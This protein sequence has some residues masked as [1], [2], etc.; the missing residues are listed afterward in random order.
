MQTSPEQRAASHGRRV[1]IWVVVVVILT[2][3]GW[4]LIPDAILAFK[5]TSTDDAYVNGHVTFVAPRVQGQVV[6]V[7]VDDNN[8]VRRGD[9]L[10]RL[11][12]QPHQA[13]VELRRAELSLA[14]AGIE[15]ARARARSL[16]ASG[17]AARFTLVD[18][19]DRVN[20]SI[21][22]LRSNVAQLDQSRALLLTAQEQFT[23][24]A[25]IEPMQA[26]S[27]LEL[28]LKRNALAQAQAAVR[29]AEDAIRQTRI[30]LGL[31]AEP[32]AG[33]GGEVVPPDLAQRHP[34]VRAAMA[35]LTQRLAELGV[36]LA[37]PAQTPA[38]LLEHFSQMESSG[39]LERWRTRLVNEAPMTRLAVAQREHAARELE[40]AELNLKYTE[41]IAEFDG[42]VSRRNVNPGDVVQPGQNLLAIRAS[43]GLWIDANFKETQLGNLRIGQRVECYTDAYGDRRVFKGRISGFSI[44]TGATLSILP[45][46]NATGNYVKV[47]QRLPV[48]IDLEPPLPDDATLFIGLSVTP[49]VFYR[50][51]PSGPNAGRMLQA[52]IQSA[53]STTQP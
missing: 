45:P 20:A 9:L 10:A 28:E 11:D 52:P 17:R 51:P 23:E 26:A 13:Q 38:Q 34:S 50:D 5:T 47:V 41:I 43:S 49:Y 2:V 21:E 29:V 14:E 30:S 39:E 25:R 4:R 6:R 27:K 32:A 44:G 22:T 46:E 48:R 35:D 33:K 53:A 19:I 42:V 16:E 1:V 37:A 24:I 7:L 8:V 31:G 12:K 36:P 18:T 3:A 15:Q 40:L